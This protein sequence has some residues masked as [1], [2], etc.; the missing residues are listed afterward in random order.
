MSRAGGFF[1]TPPGRRLRSSFFVAA[2]GFYDGWSLTFQATPTFNVSRHVALGG[3]YRADHGWFPKRHDSFTTHVTRARVQLALDARSSLD[4][5][6]QHN[7]AASLL[8]P[9]LRFRHNFGEGN[10]LWVVYDH[11]LNIDAGLSASAP[12]TRARGLIIKFTR[13]FGV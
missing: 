3:E 7:S 12:T 4:V 9:S 2:G 5:L 6:V 13:A 1:V 11:Q 10:D 8:A